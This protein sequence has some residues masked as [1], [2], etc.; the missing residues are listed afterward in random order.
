VFDYSTL[1]TF[2]SCPRLAY[3]R[4]WLGR[5]SI[6]PSYPLKWGS[7]YHLYRELLEK[8]YIKN[9]RTEDPEE[10]EKYHKVA[11]A[12]ATDGWE[13]PPLGH[14]KEFLTKVRFA[15]TCEQAFHGWKLEKHES[16]M[17]VIATEEAFELTLPNGIIF[18]GKKDQVVDWNG[19]AWV[20]DFKTTSYMGRTYANQFDPDAQ[21]TGYVWATGQ[22]SGRRVQGAIIETIYNTKTKGPEHHSFLSTRSEFHIEE[23]M[24]DIKHAHGDIDRAEADDYFPKRTSACG[25]YGGCIF[26][27][28]CSMSSWAARE[29]WL[30]NH[31]VER[32]WDF[33]A[34]EGDSDAKD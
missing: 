3:Y 10:W 8:L 6:E 28:C 21:I 31:T 7:A 18:G 13:D 9:G 1:S 32:R 15:S 4:Y 23:W 20:R 34:K 11:F 12:V 24:E 2:M 27:K 19:Q 29:E 5:D 25:N 17:V 33:A 26:R 14:K 30:E 16:R 22:L